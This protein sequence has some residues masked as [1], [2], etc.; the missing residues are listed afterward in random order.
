MDLR[1]L[2]AQ[3]DERIPRGVAGQAARGCQRERE[4]EQRTLP[5]GDIVE[6]EWP[7]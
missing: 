5:H 4:R 1:V 6:I 3:A 2:P 7:R